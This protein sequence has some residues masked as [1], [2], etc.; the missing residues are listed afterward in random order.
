M[1]ILITGGNG[2]IGSAVI[3]NILDHGEHN[4][5][6]L[7]DLTY[8]S[9]LDSLSGYDS[10][11][12]YYF[13]KVNICNESIIKNIFIKYQPDR[14]MH[15]AAE[16]HVDRSIDSSIN[17][18]NTN[19]F[20]TYNLLEQSRFYYSSLKDEKK[21]NFLFHHIS[22]DEVFG[23]LGVNEQPFTENSSYCP[24][25][26]YAASKASSDHIVRAWHRTYK[27]PIIIS[28][29]S[30]NYGPYQF[31][32]KFI[33]HTILNA[34]NGRS[35]P[36]YVNGL[37][38]RDW[39]Y[40]EDHAR[41]L[42]EV[43]FKGKN[44]ET[45]NIGGNNEKKN[46]DVALKICEILNDLVKKKPNNIKKFEKLILFVND[47]PGHDT[48]YAIN[49]SKINNQLNWFPN[50]TFE[51]GILKTVKWYL[52]NM[53]WWNKILIGEYRLERIGKNDR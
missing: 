9:S 38:I 41:A 28:N 8:S 31:P 50:E 3:R 27:L 30:N 49:S 40:V 37:Q 32:E 26:P 24:S 43:L 7:D 25:S 5:I 53:E 36:I 17:F 18:I 39:L 44:G 45:Y 46:I 2:F 48:R 23:D 12:N 42:L 16:T 21:K 29:C 10:S 20:G 15:F 47:R 14:I 19:I 22:T 6:N 11:K 1:K 13:E 34:L 4:V 52:D 35:I 51:S 33:P